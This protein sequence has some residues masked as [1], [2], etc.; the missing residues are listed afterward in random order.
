MQIPI[1]EDPIIRIQQE[2]GKIII[3][4]ISENGK[5]SKL[6][7]DYN[8]WKAFLDN[9]KTSTTLRL[10]CNGPLDV[11]EITD[12]KKG[13]HIC[14]SMDKFRSLQPEGAHYKV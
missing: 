4:T 6:I 12:L 5:K 8:E 2:E 3:T 13:T 10:V 7:A 11:A 9:P 14:I 1:F